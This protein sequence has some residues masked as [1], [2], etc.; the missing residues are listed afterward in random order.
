MIWT[1]PAPLCLFVRATIRR[2][3]YEAFKE[4]ARHVAFA[5]RQ[6]P[7]RLEWSA[8]A[9]VAGPSLAVYIIVPLDSLGA[10][11]EMVSLDKVMA[12]VY[13]DEGAIRLGEFQNCVLDMS[14]SVLNRI[15]LGL[16]PVPPRDAPA[17]YLY[18]LNI[19]V[20]PA[21]AGRFLERAREAA[22]VMTNG[23]FALYGTFAGATRVHGFALGE[24]MAD[25]ELIGRLQSR[26]ASGSHADDGE[27]IWAGIHDTLQ[28][29]ETSILRQ[30]GHDVHDQR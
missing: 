19:K 23:P 22:A 27:R 21:R 13:G 10:M 16:S 8:Y 30:I 25:L 26:I 15:D 29:T 2:E 14:T 18:Y 6:H 4:L 9:T 12:D 11:D 28:E 3:K 17:E 7:A 5:Y 1:F 20:D 24:R